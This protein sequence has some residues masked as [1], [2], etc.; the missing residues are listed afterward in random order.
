MSEMKKTDEIKKLLDERKELFKRCENDMVMTRQLLP[1]FRAV[2]SKLE[3][4][5]Y[6]DW[7]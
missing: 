3:A 4:L 1:E 6:K 7:P 2:G 5:G